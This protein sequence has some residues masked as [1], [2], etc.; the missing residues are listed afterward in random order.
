MKKTFWMWI[1]CCCILGN[2]CMNSMTVRAIDAE[3]TS[4]CSESES[5]APYFWGHYT[6]TLVKYYSITAAI[7][8]SIYYEE[9]RS[10][11]GGTFSGTLNKVNVTLRANELQYEVTFMG[12]LYGH[13]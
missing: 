3:N 2:L 1:L 10:D 9:Y 11:F 8:N 6:K 7:P 4:V 13:M 12:E 5:A